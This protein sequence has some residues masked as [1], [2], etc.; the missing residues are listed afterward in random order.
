MLLE[1]TCCGDERRKTVRLKVQDQRSEFEARHRLVYVKKRETERYAP[2]DLPPTKSNGDQNHP[3][4]IVG[5]VFGGII[6]VI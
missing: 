6:I 5:R 3:F 2:P 4:G 1:I